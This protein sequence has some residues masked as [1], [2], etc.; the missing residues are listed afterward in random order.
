MTPEPDKDKPKD[1]VPDPIAAALTK[2]LDEQKTKIAELEAKL[3]TKVDGSPLFKDIKAMAEMAIKD[4][5]AKAFPKPTDDQKKAI[6]SMIKGK[7]IEEVTSL[8][9]TY[10]ALLPPEKPVGGIPVPGKTGDRQSL[11]DKDR[12]SPYVIKDGKWSYIG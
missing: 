5:V 6:D 12:P 11:F 4:L 10:K 2:A 9:D 1:P 8:L 7:S 3:A